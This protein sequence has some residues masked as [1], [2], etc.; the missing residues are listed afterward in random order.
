MAAPPA[1]RCMHPHKLP[2]GCPTPK[3]FRIVG[4]LRPPRIASFGVDAAKSRSNFG[5]GVQCQAERCAT[6]P[7][8]RGTLI[9][10]ARQASTYRRDFRRL[11]RSLVSVATEDGQGAMQLSLR[12]TTEGLPCHAQESPPSEEGPSHFENQGNASNQGYP[13]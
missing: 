13:P 4:A 1:A 2:E 3:Q 6:T 7:A 10:C 9:K 12:V 8:S 5:V 11:V